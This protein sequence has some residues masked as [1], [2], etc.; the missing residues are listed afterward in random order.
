[1]YI[2]CFA[3]TPEIRGNKLSY[4]AWNSFIKFLNEKFPQINTDK[5]IIE[6]YLQNIVVW[7]KVMGIEVLNI[8]EIVTKP[9][10]ITPTVIMG[11]N[12]KSKDEAVEVYKE[13]QEIEELF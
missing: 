8:D 11:K 9:K 12:I 7:N 13:W 10:L 3:I 4:L 2:D 1:M 5:L 6:V